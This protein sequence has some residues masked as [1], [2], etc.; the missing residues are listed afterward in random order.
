MPFSEA[1]TL[2]LASV[3]ENYDRTGI[4]KI[5]A[6][7]YAAESGALVHAAEPAYGLSWIDRNKAVGI[8]WWDKDVL[9]EEIEKQPRP[10]SMDAD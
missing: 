9:P 10:K 5:A 7:T 4:A 6:T 1:V 2:P 8:G 3:Y